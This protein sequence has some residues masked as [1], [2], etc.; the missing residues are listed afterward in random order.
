MLIHIEIALGI[1]LEVES[2]VARHQVQHVIE[3]RIPVEISDLPRPSRF[4]RNVICVSFV[5]R[6][7]RA[8]LDMAFVSAPRR[9]I[10]VIG[11]VRIACRW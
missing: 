8:V 11:L 3:K 10:E 7:K 9:K 2:T 4:M 1:E 5:L 6:C